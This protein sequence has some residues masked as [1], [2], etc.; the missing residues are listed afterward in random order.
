[1]WASH[2]ALSVE[3]I[4]ERH[5]AERADRHTPRNKS[6]TAAVAAK[7]AASGYR[8]YKCPAKNCEN[9]IHWTTG[10][11]CAVCRG[12]GILHRKLKK[13]TEQTRRCKVCRGGGRSLVA[14]IATRATYRGA[15]LVMSSLPPCPA[16]EGRGYSYG[17]DARP[18]PEKVIGTPSAPE[19]VHRVGDLEASAVL[20]HLRRIDPEAEGCVRLMLGEFASLKLSLRDRT[21]VEAVQTI[22]PEFMLWPLTS[23]GRQL[24][25]RERRREGVQTP[26]HLALLRAMQRA[27]AEGDEL[28]AQLGSM[29]R[30]EASGMRQRAM[31]KLFIADEQT[32]GYLLR[33]AETEAR[34]LAA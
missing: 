16:C 28:A 23:Y 33:T 21:L 22:G 29:A 7:C 12:T 5:Y 8:T 26:P 19:P 11:G 25:D 9:G 3:S 6:A 17:F 1:M 27:Q 14:D 30:L 15:V 34:R 31:S 2:T 4:L 32:G 13:M 18:D 24:V 10:Q 20:E